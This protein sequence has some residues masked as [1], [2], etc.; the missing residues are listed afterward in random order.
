MLKM[1]LRILQLFMIGPIL[2]FFSPFHIC[3]SCDALEKINPSLDLY[4]IMCDRDRIEKHY[5]CK[6]LVFRCFE[7]DKNNFSEWTE[8]ANSTNNSETI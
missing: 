6:S 2:A 1:Y 7:N 8:I 3:V 5:S 4:Y